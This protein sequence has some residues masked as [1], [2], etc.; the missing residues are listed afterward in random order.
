MM[1]ETVKTVEQEVPLSVRTDIK[2]CLTS[3]KAG[4]V[5]PL[6]YV[7][8]LR[9]DRATGNLRVR[10][11][12]ME[13]VEMLMNAVHVEVRADF[14]PF[15]AFERFDGLREFNKSYKRENGLGEIEPI[16]FFEMIPFTTNHEIHRTLGIHAGTQ[17]NGAV[18][19]AYNV[20][21]NYWRKARSEN[22]P[23]RARMAST[24]ARGFWQHTDMA[25]IVPDFD[26]A[27]IEGEVPLT[28]VTPDLPVRGIGYHPTINDGTSNSGLVDIRGTGTRNGMFSNTDTIGIEVNPQTQL[29]AIFAEMEN[30]G[31][32]V[33][34]ANIDRIRKT[35]AFAEI[36]QKYHGI[37]DDHIIDLLMDGIRVPEEQL[38]Q[39]IML[40]RKKTIMGY[41]RRY[42]TDAANLAESVTQGETF[43]DLRFRTP[44]M[45]T[46]G[47][48]LVTAQIVPEQLFERK[49]DKFLYTT[50]PDQLPA[51]IRD[52]LDPE[53]VERV[54]NE[55]VDVKHSEPDETFGYAPL[56]HEWK[57]NLVNIGGKYYRPD[58]DLPADEERQKFW[59]AEIADPTLTEDFYLVNDLH[60][61]VFV[62][63][64]SDPF[65][66]TTRGVVNVVGR[67]VFGKG[68][69]EAD[70]DYEIIDAQVDDQRVDKDFTV[71]TGGG[72]A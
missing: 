45:N 16:P 50:N 27:M 29:P 6:A 52:F 25:H 64:Q 47:I 19:E 40:D 2:R 10:L 24:V 49:R 18:T 33:S 61:K 72:T 5:L 8:L 32:S 54:P 53:K 7:P 30:A 31:L 46:G 12:M 66:I 28:I 1:A 70:D 51:T 43:V 44:P 17:V 57:R 62:D 23:V 9:E 63:T 55:F 48:I 68:L 20:L 21:V 42:A 71:Q 35:Q 41:N 56:N 59:A 60:Q 4:K 15:L 58:I 38:S 11:E 13:T 65:E 3:G 36:R 26:Q 14:I 39:P 37:D 22:L 34:L 69:M 67:T